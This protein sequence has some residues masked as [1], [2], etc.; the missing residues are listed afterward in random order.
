MAAEDGSPVIHGRLHLASPRQPFQACFE[1]LKTF[2]TAIIEV[3][4]SG[5]ARA[6]NSLSEPLARICAYS[7]GHL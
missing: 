2:S 4:T 5:L 6:F 7:I 3:C 1:W